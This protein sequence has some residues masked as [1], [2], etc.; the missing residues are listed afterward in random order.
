MVSHK[1]Y[2]SAEMSLVS[3]NDLFMISPNIGISVATTMLLWCLDV[4]NMQYY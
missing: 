2:C 3:V 4:V 1:D